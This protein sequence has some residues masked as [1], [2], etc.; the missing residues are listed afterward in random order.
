M[1][2][3]RTRIAA[4]R[5]AMGEA[6]YNEAWTLYAE[7]TEMGDAGELD[8][9]VLHNLRGGLVRHIL[10]GGRVGGF[11]TALLENDLRQ[12]VVRADP[13]SFDSLRNLVRFL[14]SFAPRNCHG[15]V[16]NVSTW[17]GHG[18]YLG[19]KEAEQ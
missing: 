7:G 13:D 6:E 9:L 10:E 16:V 4:I 17:I 19:L 18:G 8:N 12:A 14:N 3:D 5:R 2:M 1:S 11:L 15:G